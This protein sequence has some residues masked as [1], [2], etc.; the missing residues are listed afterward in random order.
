VNE[1]RRRIALGKITA[2]FLRRGWR[3]PPMTDAAF[4]RITDD[5]EHVTRPQ[6]GWAS[7]PTLDMSPAELRALRLMADGLTVAEAAAQLHIG[8]ETA[9]Y[10]LKHVYEKL[11]ARN[12]AHAVAIGF[13][14]GLIS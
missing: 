13:R 10:H 12:A 1:K 8:H 7:T 4:H 11:A 9:K 5:I 14:S 3:P 2:V 6:Y